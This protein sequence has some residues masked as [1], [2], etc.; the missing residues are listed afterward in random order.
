[1]AFSRQ[2]Y[3]S[4]WPFPSS[5]ALP[6]PGIKPMSLASPALAGG[7]FTISTTWEAHVTADS[8][9]IQAQISRVC[10]FHFLVRILWQVEL[11]LNKCDAFLL[12][13]EVLDHILQP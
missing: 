5:G 2:E 7:F 4:G 6:K 9:S 3:W 1:M 8:S 13:A 11:I 10:F 12:L